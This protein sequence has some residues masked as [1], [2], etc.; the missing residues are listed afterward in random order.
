MRLR[1]IAMDVVEE[2]LTWRLTGIAA[3]LCGGHLL[4]ASTTGAT[5]LGDHGRGVLAVALWIST[6]AS[7]VGAVSFGLRGVG[8][9][10]ADGTAELM[11]VRPLSRRTWVAGRA[12]GIGLSVLGWD[13][14]VVLAWVPTA[15]VHAQLDGRLLLVWLGLCSQGLLMAGWA[16]L[17]GAVTRREVALAALGALLF[18]GVFAD[19]VLLY[20]RES[21]G[22]G[23]ALS[24]L[25]YLA[26]PDLDLFAAVTIATGGA[27]L[28]FLGWSILYSLTTATA[29]AILTAEVVSRRDLRSPS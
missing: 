24:A 9:A 12:L 25:I 1:A 27:S 15:L 16:A 4:L 5:S 8:G 23:E 10:L 18:A 20:A 17:L 7:L 6:M 28:S 14:L 3:A 21:G 2:C 29:L 11:L 19:E 26:C 13:T 22:L